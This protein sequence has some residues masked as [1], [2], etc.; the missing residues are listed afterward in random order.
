[1]ILVTPKAAA[2]Y[3]LLSVNPPLLVVKLYYFVVE[4]LRGE[5]LKL[6]WAEFSTLS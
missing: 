4:N 3:E 1:M 6:D 5:N 2:K